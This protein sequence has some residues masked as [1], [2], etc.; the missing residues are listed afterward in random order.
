M[1]MIWLSSHKATDCTE[2]GILAQPKGTLLRGFSISLDRV[3]VPPLP[4]GK[5]FDCEVY[6]RRQKQTMHV[7]RPKIR[8]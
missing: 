1:D 8:H 5:V 4:V 3:P 7:A 6:R 2:Y